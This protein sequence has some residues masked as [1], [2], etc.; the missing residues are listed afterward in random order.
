MSYYDC[1]N[2][3]LA[4]GYDGDNERGYCDLNE[5][6]SHAPGE[7]GCLFIEA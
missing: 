2:Y 5:Y 4:V 3:R 1:L 6:N 7:D